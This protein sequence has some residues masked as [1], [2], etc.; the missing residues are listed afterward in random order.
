MRS[1]ARARIRESPIE[2]PVSDVDR[3]DAALTI[4]LKPPAGAIHHPQKG[5]FDP[6]HTVHAKGRR[7]ERAVLQR[8]V[9][10][11]IRISLINADRRVRIRGSDL[12]FRDHAPC[13]A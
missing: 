11:D 12:S 9:G 5:W 4:V 13:I 8:R 7:D 2:A 6:R 1:L 3:K 10:Y